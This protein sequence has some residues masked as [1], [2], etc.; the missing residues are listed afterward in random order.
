MKSIFD[1]VTRDEVISRIDSLN[2]N[3]KAQWGTM[4]VGQMVRHCTVCEDYYFGKIKVKRSWMGMLFGRSAI[5]AI[6]KD[7]TTNINKN[8][9]AALQFKVTEHVRNLG[10]EKEK[11]KAAV[12]RYATFSNDYF[13]HWFFGKMTKK[14][15]GQFIYKHCNHHLKQFGS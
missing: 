11:W 7:E 3:S 4:T 15:L 8:A 5:N 9:P 6:L 1:Q 2:S 12:N 14:E 13:I 10:D